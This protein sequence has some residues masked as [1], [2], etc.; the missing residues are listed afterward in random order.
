MI[1]PIFDLL[2]HETHKER[3]FEREEEEEEEE[4]EEKEEAKRFFFLIFWVALILFMFV[5]EG[6]SS[7]FMGL[8]L[9]FGRVTRLKGEGE[10]RKN[11]KM[12]MKLSAGR[13]TALL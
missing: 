8:D 13:L 3:E 9:C 4:E 7:I 1:G 10:M 11:K 6:A 2:D 12:G 5:F